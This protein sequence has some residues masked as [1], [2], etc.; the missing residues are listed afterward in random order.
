DFQYPF[1]NAFWIP[2][3]ANEK[4]E[5]LSDPTATDY[6]I[7]GLLRPSVTLEHAANEMA[8]LARGSTE[9]H[10]IKRQELSVQMRELNEAKPGIGKI[11]APLL[12][13]QFAVIFVLLIAS[14]NLANLLLARN[15][16]RRQEFTIRLAI[17]AG[18]GRL[19]RQLLVE[20]LLLGLL[21]N[22]LG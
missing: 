21:G 12:A 7:L 9:Q 19:V 18:P 6:E 8:R 3:E 22:L 11:R 15:T 1:R 20:S 10:R 16:E 4:A 5:K 2:L 17:G 13:L 14:T